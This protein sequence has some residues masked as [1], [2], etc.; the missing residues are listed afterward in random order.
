[1]SAKVRPLLIAL[2]AL[3]ALPF[4][5]RA[6]GLTINTATMVVIL[7]IAALGLNLL[8]GYTGLISF[9]HSVWFG[10]GTY[11]AGLAQR[12][13]FPDS[14]CCRSCCRCSSSRRCLRSSGS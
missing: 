7:A 10:I 8:V 12:H 3:I 13:L 4:A 1:M 6:L 2:A 5:M 11:A 9:G 14:S